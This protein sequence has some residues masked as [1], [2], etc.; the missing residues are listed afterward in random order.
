[1]GV[2]GLG[3]IIARVN[4]RFPQTA[5]QEGDTLLIDGSGW[6]FALMESGGIERRECGG[7]YAAM[8]G[9]IREAVAAFERANLKIFVYRC[10]AM[11]AFADRKMEGSLSC[12][13]YSV[14]ASVRHRTLVVRRCA[15]APWLRNAFVAILL[16]ACP[17]LARILKQQQLG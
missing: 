15:C 2:R 5:L 12:V 8:D 17:V 16:H 14:I 10:A 6:A 13:L 7:D 11:K 1:M 9:A 4:D 3:A